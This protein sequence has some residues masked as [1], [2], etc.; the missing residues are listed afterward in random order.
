MKTIAIDGDGVL[1]DYNTAYAQAWFN[2]FGERLILSN[3][4][5]YWPIE[6]WSARLLAND[7]LEQFRNAFDQ[8]FWSTIPAIPG[9]LEACERLADQGYNLVCVTA[10]H[11]RFADARAHNLRH[12]GFPIS[13]VITTSNVIAG[14]S[15]K[16]RAIADL[17]PVAFVDDYSPYLVGVAPPVHLALILRDPVGSP[18]TGELLNTP[19]SSHADLLEFAN[20][21]LSREVPLTGQNG[22][23]TSSVNI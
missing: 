12:L 5:A 17:R 16:A 9:A 2:A 6:R 23:T 18:N 15:P 3:P 1:L 19:D 14:V 11:D 21:W 7:E 22:E 4:Q 10:L 8:E 13:R 20:W